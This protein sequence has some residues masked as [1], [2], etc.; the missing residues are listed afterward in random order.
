MKDIRIRITGKQFIG[1]NSEEKME[2][3]TEGQMSNRNGSYYFMYEESEF[4]GFPGCKTVLKLTDNETLRMK[5]IGRDTGYGAELVFAKGEKFTNSYMTPYGT[6]N[7]EVMTE[8]FQ[9]DF[10]EE[11][12]GSI[13]IDYH[14]VFSDLAEGYNRLKI[15]IMM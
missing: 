4:S 11:K 3:I 10:D 1:D 12:G 7:M 5:R 15:D 14:V 13:S 8:K 9:S 2:F 6:F